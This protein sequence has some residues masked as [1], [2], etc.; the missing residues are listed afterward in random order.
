M[1]RFFVFFVDLTPFL[2]AALGFGAYKYLRFRAR[3]ARLARKP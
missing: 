1:G 2:G 3:R